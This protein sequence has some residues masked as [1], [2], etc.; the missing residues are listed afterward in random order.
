[1]SN[2]Q[3]HAYYAEPLASCKRWRKNDH[4]EGERRLSTKH[5]REVSAIV[6][7]DNSSALVNC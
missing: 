1:M 5:G 4:G 6:G 7:V 3:F 2:G